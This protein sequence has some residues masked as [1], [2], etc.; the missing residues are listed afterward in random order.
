MET[1]KIKAKI[2]NKDT[3]FTNIEENGKSTVTFFAEQKRHLIPKKYVATVEFDI[4]YYNDDYILMPACAYNGNRFPSVKKSYPPMFSKEEAEIPNLITDVPRLNQ[5]GSGKIEVTS[6]D[7]S[8]PCVAVWD[9]FKKKAVLLFFEQEL[10]GCDLGVTYSK[11]K[12]EISYPKYREN[13]YKM[14]S[15]TKSSDKKAFFS[16][17]QRFDFRYLLIETDC[18]SIPQLMRIFF[19]NRKAMGL[20]CSSPI[21]L[22]PKEMWNIQEEKINRLNYNEKLKIYRNGVSKSRF[23]CWQPGWTG[24]LISS[25]PLMKLGS[26]KTYQRAKNCVD[27]LI[28]TQ[29]ENGLFESVIDDDGVGYGDGFETE[30]TRYWHLLRK[31]ADCLYFLYDI[32]KVMEEKGDEV[33]QNYI[34]GYRKLADA[35]CEIFTK[36]KQ[37]GQ[38]V[39][40]RTNEIIVPGSASAGIAVGGL[41]RAYLYL[42]DE[43]YLKVASECADYLHDN[44]VSNGFTNGG[45]GEML[46]CCDSESAFGTLEGIVTLY[47]VTKD[48]KHLKYCEDTASLASTWVMAYN[49]NYPDNCSFK[50]AGI[51]T[52]GTV[53]ANLQ[54]KHSAPGICTL[55]GLALK[56]LYDITGDKLY[57]ELITDIARAIGQC[58][59]T[60]SHPIYCRDTRKNAP[61]GYICERVNTS[62][63]EGTNRVGEIFGEGSNWC[64]VS[65]MLTIADLSVLL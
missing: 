64:E 41:A 15:V 55:S 49:Y 53:F 4:S 23:A 56:K 7:M 35:F 6:A 3:K 50:K 39:D 61:K 62:D 45:P 42:N 36:N 54:N 48:S 9:K 16:P 22:S 29:Y 21:R 12:I 2:N 26:E 38:F 13:G 47:E 63:W 34:D 1:V 24:N 11:G 25:Y 43:K 59:S 51:K 20:D 5:D 14:C 40:L 46:Q 44:F 27:F 37:L 58:M 17:N 60:D 8:V 32:F 18:E 31:S 65:N 19:E 33:E 10:Y 52:V 28:K 57:L 30:G